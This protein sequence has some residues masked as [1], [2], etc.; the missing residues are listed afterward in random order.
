MAQKGKDGFIYS[1]KKRVFK[2]FIF[3]N[4]AAKRPA[5]SLPSIRRCD[6]PTRQ[7]IFIAL[8]PRGEN[9]KSAVIIAL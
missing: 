9:L 6:I 2:G 3:Q 7:V 4:G 8:L 1:Y 5:V